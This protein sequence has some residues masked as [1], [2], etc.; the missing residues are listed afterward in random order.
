MRGGHP[1]ERLHRGG[2]NLVGVQR[3]KTVDVATG[4]PD[5][6]SQPLGDVRGSCSVVDRGHRRALRDGAVEESSCERHRQQR[7]HDAATRR[8]ARDRHV[9]R[10]A[11][12]RVDG[13]GHPAQRGEDVAEC[14]VGFVSST[15]G[16]VGDP[17]RTRTA[18]TEIGEAERAE[19]VVQCHHHDVLRRREVGAVVDGLCAC[20]ENVCATVNPHHDRQPPVISRRARRRPDVEEQAVLTLDRVG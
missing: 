18:C 6:S 15:G 2:D 14:R 10:I 8:L 16:A 13:V 17:A 19:S 5:G 1:G 4:A 11:A 9:V 20:T 7:R 12:E 3:R